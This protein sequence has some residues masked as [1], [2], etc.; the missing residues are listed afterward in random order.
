MAD[1]LPI[2]LHELQR[3]IGEWA[4]RTFPGSH[5]LS[6]I[7]HL[8]D[9]LGELHEAMLGLNDD[10]IVARGNL[11]LELADVAL[12]LLHLAHKMGLDLY[13]AILDK[14]DLN[15]RRTWGQADARGVVRH[16]STGES[17]GE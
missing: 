10:G 1:Q 13:E 9:E 14:H 2:S 11:R 4:D 12:L 3:L 7:A 5:P 16:V 17:G 15:Q 6:V 8:G